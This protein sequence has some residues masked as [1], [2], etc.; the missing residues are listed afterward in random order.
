MPYYQMGDVSGAPPSADVQPYPSGAAAPAAS[1]PPP[2]PPFA[3]HAMMPPPQPYPPEPQGRYIKSDD[4]RRHSGAGLPGSTGS[5]SSPLLSSARQP[6]PPPPPQQRTTEDR[7]PTLTGAASPAG[8]TKKSPLSLAAI[9][10]P[11]TPASSD[12]SKNYH[13]QTLMLGER[14]RPVT[15]LAPEDPALLLPPLL[16]FTATRLNPR[17]RPYR[18]R[19][20]VRRTCTSTTPHIVRDGTVTP[21]PPTRRRQWCEGRRQRAGPGPRSRTCRDR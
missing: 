8:A 18:L 13:A 7:S 9:T 6:P 2:P 10:S 11:F 20:G 21:L 12:Q 16:P 19:R 4:T 14:L 15:S 17:L 5:G 3:Y 1:A